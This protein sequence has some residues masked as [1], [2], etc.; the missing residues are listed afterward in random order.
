MAAA[1]RR[2]FIL[3]YSY[4]V[5]CM[6]WQRKGDNNDT[7]KVYIKVLPPSLHIPYKIK[8]D[9]QSNSKRIF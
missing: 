4:R 3:P 2:F 9:Y 7:D 5:E 6:C 8:E 1:D